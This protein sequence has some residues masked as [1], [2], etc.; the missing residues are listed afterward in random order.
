MILFS[1]AKSGARGNAAT[2]MVTKPNWIAEK[3]GIIDTEE[4]PCVFSGVLL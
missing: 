4:M 1:S 3:K 2:K